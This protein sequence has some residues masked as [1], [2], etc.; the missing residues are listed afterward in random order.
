MRA[1]TAIV[2]LKH[3]FPPEPLGADVTLGAAAPV[4]EAAPEEKVERAPA[5]G[6]CLLLLLLWATST[7]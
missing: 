5:V 7:A 1:Q 6:R 3:G 4:K 2:A